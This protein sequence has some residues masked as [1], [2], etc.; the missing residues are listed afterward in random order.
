[1]HDQRTAHTQ[2]LNF[3]LPPVQLLDGR[4]IRC[5]MAK[6]NPGTGGPMGGPAAGRGFGPPGGGIASYLHA[7]SAW[8]SDVCA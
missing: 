7:L 3:D 8:S 5:N 1:M 4:P 2:I 6:Y